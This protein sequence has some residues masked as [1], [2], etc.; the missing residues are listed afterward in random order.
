V[1]QEKVLNFLKNKFSSGEYFDTK[2]IANN[3]GIGHSTVVTNCKRLRKGKMVDYKRDDWAFRYR[4][5]V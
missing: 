4:H 3:I 1:S 5:Q 2:T